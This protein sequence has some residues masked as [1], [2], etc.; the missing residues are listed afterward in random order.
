MMDDIGIEVK[1]ILESF[2]GEPT[3]ERLRLRP[4]QISRKQDAQI[5]VFDLGQYFNFFGHDAM[6]PITRVMKHAVWRAGRESPRSC[7][8]IARLKEPL[9]VSCCDGR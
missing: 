9:G 5:V 7:Y 2:R 3:L 1:N 4:P 6:E 8:Q